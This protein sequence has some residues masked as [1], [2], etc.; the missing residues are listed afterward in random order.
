M[1]YN[2]I[3]SMS[4]SIS[5]AQKFINA[6]GITDST[7]KSAINTLVNDLKSYGLWTKLKAIYPMVGGTATTHKYNLKDPRDDNTAF[8]LT[9][10]GGWTHSNNGALPNGTTGYADTNFTGSNWSGVSNASMG[11]Y[12]RTNFLNTVET[13]E[14]GAYGLGVSNNIIE[15]Y[16]PTYKALFSLNGSTVPSMVTANTTTSTGLYV[17]NRTGTNVLNGWKNGTKLGTN[18]VS[19]S[20]L[21]TVNIYIGGYNSS[22]VPQVLSSKE[23]AFSFLGDGFTD[24]ES[25]NLYTAIQAFQTTLGRQV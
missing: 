20:S 17:A 8:R 22:G 18:T 15:V 14:M 10:T 25:G 9:F 2:L 16:N 1:Y 4:K 21:P 7:Q 6:T 3:S 12:S 13:V 5:D 19:V 23:C 24:T 11:F